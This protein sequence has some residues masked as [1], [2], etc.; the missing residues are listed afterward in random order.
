MARSVAQ[1]RLEIAAA[2]AETAADFWGVLDLVETHSEDFDPD[3]YKYMLVCAVNQI[4][5]LEEAVA[6]Y[7]ELDA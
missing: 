1:M 6:E 7:K 3:A 5:N 2:T 4:E